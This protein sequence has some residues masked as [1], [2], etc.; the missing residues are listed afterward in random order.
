MR[1]LHAL[2]PQ[3]TY[4]YLKSSSGGLLV[5]IPSTPIHSD[6]STKKAIPAGL[7]TLLYNSVSLIFLVGKFS[8]LFSHQ[9]TI[10]LSPI[11]KSSPACVLRHRGDSRV[12][13]LH[14]PDSSLFYRHQLVI[15]ECQMSLL[16]THHS[17]TQVLLSIL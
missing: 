4:F 12:Y 14:Q 10:N 6:S 13:F 17:L 9:S 1:N 8:A 11:L 2:P 5:S 7:L 3:R 15:F 16:P